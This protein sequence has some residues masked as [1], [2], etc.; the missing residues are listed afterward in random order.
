MN[1]SSLD[2]ILKEN[3]SRETRLPISVLTH[4]GRSTAT[5]SGYET[6]ELLE[7]RDRRGGP[8]PQ[9]QFTEWFLSTLKKEDSIV[10]I[11]LNFSI[12]FGFE[13]PSPV[14]ILKCKL[15]SSPGG[16]ALGL[17]KFQKITT[18]VEAA[19]QIETGFVVD[20]K[21]KENMEGFVELIFQHHPCHH[22][23]QDK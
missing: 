1:F 23:I 13:M 6:N 21:S 10:P 12:W 15:V 9:Q 5:I 14:R 17:E 20:G 22:V 18:P 16:F 4:S 2:R 19:V 7:F 3:P 8:T 11:I